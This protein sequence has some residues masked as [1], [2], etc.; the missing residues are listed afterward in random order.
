MDQ[1]VYDGPIIAFDN[2]IQKRW[3]GS[4]YAVSA[5]QAANN[6]AFRFKKENGMLPSA[7]VSVSKLYL[8]RIEE[9]R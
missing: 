4:T 1:Y 8:K 5:A 7:K 6:L 9:R 3:K 2:C